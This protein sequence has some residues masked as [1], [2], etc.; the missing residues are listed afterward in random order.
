M[1]LRD[2]FTIP[3]ALMRGKS[4]HADASL[5][6]HWQGVKNRVHLHDKVNHFDARVI[7]DTA[8]MQWSAREED[9]TF[10]SDPE[11]TSTTVFAEI[12]RERNGVFF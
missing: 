3:N 5:S 6:V 9:F 7:E 12:G 10:V 8:T 2:F 11:E 1:E 4:I